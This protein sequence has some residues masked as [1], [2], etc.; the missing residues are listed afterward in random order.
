MTQFA[1]Q[2][3]QGCDSEDLSNYIS[4]KDFF[5]EKVYDR[6]TNYHVSAIKCTV[7][8][9][10]DAIKVNVIIIPNKAFCIPGYVYFD[11]VYHANTV[12]VA[13]D[14]YSQGR[15]LSVY[16]YMK[17]LD[18]S[19]IAGFTSNLRPILL[20][21]YVNNPTFR[22]SPLATEDLP[23]WVC[24]DPSVNMHMI[25]TDF[26][27][28]M[29]FDYTNTPTCYYRTGSGSKAFSVVYKYAN[30]TLSSVCGHP[31]LEAEALKRDMVSRCNFITPDSII[32]CPYYKEDKFRIS[33]IELSSKG[34]S[35]D[36]PIKVID[37]YLLRNITHEF[38]SIIFE[39]TCLTS[40]TI[41]TIKRFSYND[42]FFVTDEDRE[43]LIAEVQKHTAVLLADYAADYNFN[44]T[45]DVQTAEDFR[46][47]L[48]VAAKPSYISKVILQKKEEF[49]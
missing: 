32:S 42:L 36:S 6:I 15:A 21:Y 24:F 14:G 23:N 1:L 48:Q 30:S 34:M 22:S 33:T 39:E 25:K 19:A 28:N 47:G 12:A 27:F 37:S 46:R 29:R 3:I 18:N 31:Q 9:P 49:V 11:F 13:R 38:Y 45:Y 41:S 20:A 26:V 44:T 40:G 7:D 10:Q 43:K 35:S 8:Y 17:I 4:G 2:Y 5:I 16:C